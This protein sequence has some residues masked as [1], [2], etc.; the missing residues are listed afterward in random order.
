VTVVKPHFSKRRWLQITLLALNALWIGFMLVFI[1]LTGKLPIMS[2]FGSAPTFIFVLVP[3]L[4]LALTPLVQR[5]MMLVIMACIGGVLGAT[6]FELFLVPL[7]TV[8][9]TD[10]QQSFT[11]F[12]WNSLMWDEKKDKDAFYHF[13]TSQQAD[14][15]M[16]QE[17]LYSA[18]EHDATVD[19]SLYQTAIPISTA[20]DGLDYDYLTFDK[21]DEILSYFPGYYLTHQQQF[22]VISKFPIVQSYLDSS[23]QFQVVDV[24]IK[25]YPLRLF[26]VHVALHLEFKNPATLAFYQALERRFYTRAIAFDQLQLAIKS[27]NSDY[28]VAG[29][30]NSPKTMGTMTQLKQSHVDL[31]RYAPQRVPLTFEFNGLRL[32]RFDYMFAN[33]EHRFN[34]IDFHN[35]PVPALSDHNAQRL[36]IAIDKKYLGDL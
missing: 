17:A 5:R 33:N 29:D 34:V 10:T 32:W 19:K 13:L 6:Q 12:N 22:M 23:D 16:L 4:L 31:F 8:G 7:K 2:I 18:S 26:N 1:G 30:F 25:D 14:I 9:L 24:A 28:L 20:V 27:T 15:Y 21:S 35:F 3:L 11:V 36:V